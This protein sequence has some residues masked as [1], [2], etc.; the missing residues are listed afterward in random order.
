MAISTNFKNLVQKLPLVGQ[1]ANILDNTHE[2]KRKSQAKIVIIGLENSGKS[3]ILSKVKK[4]KKQLWNKLK[5]QKNELPAT[6][7]T[8]GF[9]VDVFKF[10]NTTFSLYE[11][12]GKFLKT[13]QLAKHYFEKNHAVIFVV[14][15]TDR[16]KIEEVRET[17][18]SVM[19]DTLLA[20]CKVLVLANK[21]DLDES[22]E[23]DEMVKQLKL[24]EIK[25]KWQIYGTSA[26]NGMGLFES[27]DWISM[28]N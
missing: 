4:M 5:K 16:N 18:H 20:G 11:I 14:D 27:F 21:Q 1:H 2:E 9:N 17:L 23:L 10:Q 19:Q 26:K 8:L 3:S 12:G 24:N 15:S 6:S 28:V 13:K 22:M 7:P 25:Q